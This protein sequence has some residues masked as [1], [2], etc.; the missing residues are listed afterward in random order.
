MLA[1]LEREIPAGDYSFEPKWDGF[2]CMV[3]RSG[4]ELEMWSRNELDLTRYFPELVEELLAHLPDRVVL[5]GEVVVATGQGLD[6][7][8]LSQRVHPAPSRVKRLAAETPASFV[9]FDLLAL[10]DK[11]LSRQPFRSRRLELEGLSCPG[12][13]SPHLTPATLD[14]EVAR[15]W[16]ERFE[17]AGLDGVV[18]KAPDLRYMPGKR[19]MIKVKHERTAEFVVGGFRWYRPARAAARGS[20]AEAGTEVGSLLLGLYGPGGALHHVGVIGAFSAAHRSQLAGLLSPYA[21]SS[22]GHYEHPWVVAS[23]PANLPSRLPGA[24]SRWQGDKDLSFV[25]LRPELVVEAAYEHLQCDRLRHGARFLR[26]RP[27]RSPLSCTYEQ[28]SVAAPFLLADVFAAGPR[29]GA[30]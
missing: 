27:D 10:G 24:R 8:A 4:G 30:T 15:E 1:R 18:A 14:P 20:E 3:F 16:F 23:Q 17:G 21:L 7:D 19:A 28:L 25:A 29:P 11:D 6:F 26:W 22:A 2:R 9:A 5:D 13:Q 12:R